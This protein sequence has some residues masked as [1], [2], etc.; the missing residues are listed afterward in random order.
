[1]KVTDR[2]KQPIRC[3]NDVAPSNRESWRAEPGG[4]QEAVV[5]GGCRHKVGQRLEGGGKIRHPRGEEGANPRGSRGCGGTASPGRG[6]ERAGSA[7]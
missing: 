7:D 2:S 4:R 3:E 5:P 6:S 1:M